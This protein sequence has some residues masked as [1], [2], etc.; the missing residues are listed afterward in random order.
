MGIKGFSKAFNFTRIV[1]LKDLKRQRLA[2]DA[3]TE[4]YRSSLGAKYVTALTDHQGNPTLYI[5]VIL[6]NIFKFYVNYIDSTWTFDHNQNKDQAFHNTLK[7]GELEKRSKKQGLASEKINKLKEE[8]MF[9]DDEL[10]ELDN[11][12][13]GESNASFIKDNMALGLT[14]EDANELLQSIDLDNDLD[15]ELDNDLDSDDGKMS[16]SNKTKSSL[17]KSANSSAP[18]STSSSK[19]PSAERKV[20]IK[21]QIDALEKQTFKVNTQMINDIKF[22]LDCL[23]IKWVEAP[24]GFEGEAIAAYLNATSAVDAVYSGDTDPIAFGAPIL[25]RLNPKDKQIYEY[26]QEDVLQQITNSNDEIEEP[27]LDDFLKAAVALGTD[28]AEKTTGVGPKTVLKKLHNIKLT[29][30]QKEA[31]E[32]FKKQPRQEDIVI[33]NADKT[34]FVECRMEELITWL[35]TVKR[36]KESIWRPRFE[37]AAARTAVTSTK[38]STTKTSSKKLASTAKFDS[39]AKS[40]S[41]TSASKQRGIKSDS[42]MNQKPLLRQ[43][44]P[45]ELKTGNTVSKTNNAVSKTNNAGLKTNKVLSKPS[46]VTGGKTSLQSVKKSNEIIHDYNYDDEEDESE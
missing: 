17:K 18:K 5:S 2:I 10:D 3:M 30:S 39:S 38:S 8:A 33:H 37:T 28:M 9:S 45:V 21:Q 42:S 32:H 29:K 24:A 16:L 4:L 34:P 6:Q 43:F 27:D 40:T 25:L 35:V 20:Q 14:E 19:K 41:T 7:L 26:T 22:I 15:N 31:I 46:K 1:K 11:K 12:A 13:D 23:N 36:F 44:K